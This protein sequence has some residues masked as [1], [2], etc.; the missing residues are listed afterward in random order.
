MII[1][2]ENCVGKE[3]ALDEKCISSRIQ[4]KSAILIY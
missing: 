1:G 4:S 2:E 3:N